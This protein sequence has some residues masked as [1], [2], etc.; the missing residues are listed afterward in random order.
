MGSELDRAVALLGPLEGRIMRAVWTGQVPGVFVVRD[1]QALMPEL[2]Y[3]TVMT[4]LR[5]LA[6][7]GVLAARAEPGRKAHRYRAAATPAG[8]LAAASAR[9]A[10]DVVDRYGEAA[11]L[12][13]DR[14]WIP[15]AVLG[16]GAAV[17]GGM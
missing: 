12:A 14:R 3:T 15:L 13:R 7:K 6:A 8:F 1:V 9:E 17:H 11:A 2:A 16:G 4:T 5:R 10:A